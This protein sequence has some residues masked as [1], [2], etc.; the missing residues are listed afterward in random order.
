M[1][2]ELAKSVFFYIDCVCIEGFCPMFIKLLIVF[3]FL[4]CWLWGLII[5]WER[6]LP[7]YLWTKYELALPL[8][9]VEIYLRTPSK[10]WYN[11]LGILDAGFNPNRSKIDTAT[12]F[13]NV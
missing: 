8:I 6:G 13:P 12:L 2:C 10:F 3:E 7:I 1:N 4:F 11:V 5:C 9:C